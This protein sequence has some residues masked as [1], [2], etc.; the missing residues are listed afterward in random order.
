MVA[1]YIEVLHEDVEVSAM[2]VDVSLAVGLIN[3]GRGFLTFL[4]LE[5]FSLES[6][7]PDQTN[8]SFPSLL[9]CINEARATELG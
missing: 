5:I 3:G 9:L 6:F 8:S 4:I 7:Q 2:A 1:A